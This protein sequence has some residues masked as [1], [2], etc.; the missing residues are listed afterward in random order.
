MTEETTP[1]I[2]NGPTV[3]HVYEYTSGHGH[4]YAICGYK[5]NDPDRVDNPAHADR[6]TCRNC[7]RL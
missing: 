7:I 1:K 2:L 4:Y 5:T 3:N 6:E